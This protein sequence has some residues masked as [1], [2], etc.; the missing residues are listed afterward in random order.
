MSDKRTSLI[1]IPDHLKSVWDEIKK[2]AENLNVGVGVYIINVYCKFKGIDF[3]AKPD[4]LDD[5]K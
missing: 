1:Y 3:P 4:I 2:D 5:N